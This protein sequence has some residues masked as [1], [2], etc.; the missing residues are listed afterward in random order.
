MTL[1]Q[2]PPSKPIIGF[3]VTAIPF[4]H[5][6]D[7][8]MDWAKARLSKMVC[9]ANVHMLTEAHRKPAFASVLRGADLVTPDGMPLVW[10]LRL[11]G[12]GNQDRVAGLDVLAALCHRASIDRVGVFFLGAETDILEKMKTRLA[13]EFPDLPIVGMEPLP[14]R[15]L[16][17]TEEEEI[18]SQINDSGAGL[19]FVA[20]GC[21]KQE[22]WMAEHRGRIP[23]VMIGL[24]AVFAVYAGLYRR[25]PYWIRHTGF[26]WLYR[27][28]QEP[29]RLLGRYSSTIPIFIWLAIK[30]L[31]VNWWIHYCSKPE[32]DRT[33]NR[34]N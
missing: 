7:V 30:Q 10:M 19:V 17:P 31:T 4:D 13:R 32:L 9:I 12:V 15:P 2:Y 16:T 18:V 34:T 28:V 3:P 24:G 1:D 11:L 6:I 22:I 20:L 14:F 25:A 33:S 5:Q 21:P 26:E 8:M 23:A 27:L 29:R